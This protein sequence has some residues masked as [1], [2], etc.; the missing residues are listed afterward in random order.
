MVSVSCD[1][2]TEELKLPALILQPLIENA[3]K[4][5]L[6]ESDEKSEIKIT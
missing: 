2:E 3:I 4:Y 6:Y 5:S 1:K